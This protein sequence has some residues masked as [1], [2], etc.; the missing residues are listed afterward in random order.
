MLSLITATRHLIRHRTLIIFCSSSTMIWM[1]PVSKIVRRSTIWSGTSSVPW[2]SYANML[3]LSPQAFVHAV[4][5]G[6]KG[7]NDS[8]YDKSIDGDFSFISNLSADA[9]K[10]SNYVDPA[11]SGLTLYWNGVDGYVI[12]SDNGIC[13]PRKA[14]IFTI[15]GSNCEEREA[16]ARDVYGKVMPFTVVRAIRNHGFRDGI[17]VADIS[18]SVEGGE[19]GDWMATGV[20]VAEHAIVSDVTAAQV[21]VI[22]PN[23][24]DDFPPQLIKELAKV[25]FDRNTRIWDKQWGIFAA[26]HAA[27]LADIE[28]FELSDKLVDGTIT[29]P[30]KRQEKADS[31]AR[32]MIIKKYGL[33]K[34]WVSTADK[35]GYFG[36]RSTDHSREHM[37]ITE[38]DG[39]E[40]SMADLHRCLT[41]NVSGT[42][43]LQGCMPTK[44]EIPIPSDALGPPE[45]PTSGR[46]GN[47]DCWGDKSRQ[48][49]SCR[50]LTES[51]LMSMRNASMAEVRKAMQVDGRPFENGLHFISNYSLGTRWGSGDVN[52]TFDD[53]GR[54]MVISASLDP[55]KADG[56]IADFM[57]N[58][59]MLPTGCSD[60]PNSP[61]KGCN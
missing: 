23:P 41:T 27:T 19:P 13:P 44:R 6:R 17:V 11:S 59:E 49:I 45:H 5:N 36:T 48:D 18:I 2:G 42:P 31:A 1:I 47:A 8:H 22:V 39:I 43:M 46:P 28:Y 35:I 20:Y 34:D 52:F 12:Q 33:P 60:L 55:P 50:N 16:A 7:F 57:W 53:Q 56:K 15:R 3:M 25:Y 58:R 29:D 10:L 61:L 38:P 4:N 40:R 54:V 51:F 32:K 21:L 30:D 24:E 14:G 37:Q 9:A 26:D